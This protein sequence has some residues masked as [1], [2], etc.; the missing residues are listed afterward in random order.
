[1]KIIWQEDAWADYLAWQGQDKKTLRRINQLILDISRNGNTGIGKP[2]PLRNDK[3]G[4]WS[5]RID[6]TNRIVYRLRD[7]YIE[8]AQC[9]T[10]YKDK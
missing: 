5:R 4:F 6:S 9:G 8:I 10:H 3:S 1:M 7:G 2:E